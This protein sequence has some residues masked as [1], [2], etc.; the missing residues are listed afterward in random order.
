MQMRRSE[1]LMRGQVYVDTWPEPELVLFEADVAY[2][3]SVSSV[4]T[5]C[6]LV[7]RTCVD[8]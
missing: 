1:H 6:F 7:L 5:K 4:I 2:K 8:W 3:T